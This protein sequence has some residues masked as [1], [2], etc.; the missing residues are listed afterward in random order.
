MFGGTPLCIAVKVYALLFAKRHGL[1]S[2]SIR[3]VYT[4]K[5]GASLVDTLSLYALMHTTQA[6][7]YAANTP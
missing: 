6:F 2:L 4:L 5:H 7:D 3:L 1:D